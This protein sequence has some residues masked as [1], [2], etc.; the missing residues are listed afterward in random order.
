MSDGIFKVIGTG[1]DS[2]LGGDDFDRLFA[3]KIL[4]DFFHSS[5]EELS[6]KDKTK[7]IRKSKILKENLVTGNKIEDLFE[8]NNIKKKIEIDS[9]FLNIS[10]VLH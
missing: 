1:G 3:E 6:V 10:L 4:K 5:L 7:I 8:L 9:D 2:K